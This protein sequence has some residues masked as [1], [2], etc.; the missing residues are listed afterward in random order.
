VRPIPISMGR[1][2]EKERA[3]GR[4]ALALDD[5]FDDDVGIGQFENRD[6]VLFAAG[7]LNARLDDGFDV[8]VV[9]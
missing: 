8:E 9:F 2:L 7:D 6:V 1:E 5:Q 4:S 3:A